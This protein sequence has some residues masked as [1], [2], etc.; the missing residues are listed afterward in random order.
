MKAHPRLPTRHIRVLHASVP[1]GDQVVV[2]H[3]R[4]AAGEGWQDL[5][6]VFPA[7]TGGPI[8]PGTVNTA[9]HTAL[10]L[11]GLP[12]LRVHELRDTAATLLLEQ[13]IYPKLVQDLLGHSS[14]AL[15][16][17]TYSHVT[18]R[19]HQEAADTMQGLLFGRPSLKRGNPR[20]R[21]NAGTSEEN[22]H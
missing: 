20:G 15:R 11:A 6:L 16:L 10:H 4:Q 1:S 3:L 13:G 19:L 9:L 18:P 5:N 12:R 7:L 2:L 14:I 21:R 22:N 17:D 8:D